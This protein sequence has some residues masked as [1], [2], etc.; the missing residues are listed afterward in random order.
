MKYATNQTRRPYPLSTS[1]TVRPITSHHIPPPPVCLRDYFATNR[2]DISLCSLA[3]HKI[4]C[5]IGESRICIIHNGGEGRT[6]GV[7]DSGPEEEEGQLPAG[8]PWHPG[9]GAPQTTTG[10]VCQGKK[11]E[12]LLSFLSPFYSFLEIPAQNGAPCFWQTFIF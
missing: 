3:N 5:S 10:T 12:L 2:G 6:A 7:Q 4:H 11:Y 8:E 1:S 9:G